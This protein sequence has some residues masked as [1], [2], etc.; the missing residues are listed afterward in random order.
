MAQCTSTECDYRAHPAS[1]FIMHGH[2]VYSLS[3]STEHVHG[4][5][6]QSTSTGHVHGG[7][8]R[9]TSTKHRPIPFISQLR[10]QPG[11]GRAAHSLSLTSLMHI[12]RR[13]PDLTVEEQKEC[14]YQNHREPINHHLGT[15][16]LSHLEPRNLSE[17]QFPHVCG[18]D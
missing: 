2:S 7:H 12:L 11:A 14:G 17:P 5:H 15:Y 10:G 4:V 18:E 6:S 1:V 8:L 3:T 13:G 16:Q 9:S